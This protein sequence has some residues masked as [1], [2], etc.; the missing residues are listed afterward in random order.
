MNRKIF[1][2]ALRARFPSGI[3]VDQVTR[4]AAILDGLEKRK[5]SLKHAAYILGTAHH[6]TGAFV[7]MREIWGPTPVQLRYEGRHDLGNTQRGDGKKFLGRG[8]IQ[9]TGRR[10]YTM[11]ARRLGVD[12]VANPQLT[13]RLDLAT[14]I[15]IDGMIEGTFTGKKLADF[16]DY[17]QM[18]RVVNAMDRSDRIAI[19]AREY[20]QALIASQYDKPAP[21]IPVKPAPTP[22]PPVAPL[23]VNPK[24][25]SWLVALFKA[26][27]ALF[28]RSK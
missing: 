15:L 17:K 10:N 2:D 27:V 16:R 25:D 8:F 5:V 20:E 21:V 4:I 22:Q 9:I 6:E 7:Y 13:E 14:I 23:P 18:R 24:N 12:I 11:W 28:N 1:F 3:K 26:I 19:Y